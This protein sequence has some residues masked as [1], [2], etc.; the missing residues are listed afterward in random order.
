MTTFL[1]FAYGSNMSTPRLVQRTQSARAI[2]VAR[3]GWHRLRFH[4]ISMDGSAKCD[5]EVTGNPH[6]T[7]YGVVFRIPASEKPAL[8][9]AE[10]LGHGYVEKTVS[11]IGRSGEMHRAVAYCATV[12]DATLKPYHWYKEH[13]VRG[14]REHLLPPEYVRA[15]EAIESVSDPDAARH[16]LEISIYS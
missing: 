4:K 1:Y 9:K 8:D 11:V 14:G 3:L 6:D 7:V 16:A 13:V 12:L 10:G 15:I 2:T 5:I